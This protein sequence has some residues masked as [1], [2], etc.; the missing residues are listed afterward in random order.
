MRSSK[1]VLSIFASA[2]CDDGIDK[3]FLLERID[4]Y[5]DILKLASNFL[6]ELPVKRPREE[7]R[8]V[9]EAKNS[10]PTPGLGEDLAFARAYLEPKPFELSLRST[11]QKKNF[12]STPTHSGAA[13]KQNGGSY[14]ANL[15]QDSSGSARD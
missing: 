1:N 15:F 3:M 11:A 8:L 10:G 7:L 13:A 14:I 4:Y 12:A 9:M 5:N 2:T 6:A